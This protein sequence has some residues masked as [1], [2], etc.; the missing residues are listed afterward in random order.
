M[1][2]LRLNLITNTWVAIARD[3]AKRPEE[4]RNLKAKQHHLNNHGPCPF[5]PGNEHITPAEIMR[6]PSNGG[7]KIR[8]IPNKFPVVSPEGE[9]ARVNDGLKHSVGG[10]GRHEVIIE[11]PHHDILTAFLDLAELTDIINVY[12]ERFIDAYRDK[13]VEHVIIFKNHGPAS[14]TTIEH[15]HSQLIA[16]PVKPFQMRMRIEEALRYFDNTGECLMCAIIRDEKMD[17][18][19]IILET[20][21]FIAFVPYAALSPF[22]IWIFPK[23][24]SPSF[25]A[26]TDEEIRDLAM[27]LKITLLKLHKGL[28]NPDFNYVLR[29]ERPNGLLFNHFHWYISIVPRIIQTSGIELGSGIYVNHS[30][31]EEVAEFMRSAKVDILKSDM[32]MQEV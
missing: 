28:E 23:R 11:T 13:T 4:F 6:L 30:M 31:P 27:N 15:S 21:H 1:T 16:F 3:K 2:E 17:E 14:G 7:W 29:S 26:I 20:E 22:H 18:K 25:G 12:Q 8:V 5:C 24:H 9:I 19:R 32:A 10:V